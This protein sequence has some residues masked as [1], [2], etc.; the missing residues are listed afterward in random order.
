MTLA[1]NGFG[2]GKN[3]SRFSTIK[4]V[5]HLLTY[6]LVRLNLYCVSCFVYGVSCSVENKVYA[7]VW[8]DVKCLLSIIYEKVEDRL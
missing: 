6:N 7:G 3:P 8:K 2:L 4:Q 1:M 5:E